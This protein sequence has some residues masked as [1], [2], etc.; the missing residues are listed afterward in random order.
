MRKLVLLLLFL[1]SCQIPSQLP[2]QKTAKG[3]V[4][5]EI[6]TGTSALDVS[7]NPN[8]ISD[9]L[10]C[11]QANVMVDMRNSG[12]YNIDDGSFTF[13]FE[14][15]YF[16]AV[17]SSKGDFSL[18]G[19]S[20]FNPQGD[21]MLKEFRIKNKGLPSQLE[22]Y[23]S[24]L[25]FLACY[26]YKTFGTVQVCVDPDIMNLNPNKPCRIEPVA[27]SGGQGAPVAVTRV[28]TLMV[29][30]EEQVRPAFAVFIQHLGSGSVVS[31]EGAKLACTAEKIK[32][33]EL[34][35]KVSVNVKVKDL[36]LDCP[37]ELVRLEADKE[38]RVICKFP[39]LIGMNSGTYST[40]LSV[41]IDYGYVSSALLPVSV[42]RL[43][44]QT[45][46]TR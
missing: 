41:E 46:C 35:S 40:V 13:I 18:D 7:F 38:S 8:S 22:S 43:A 14:D 44:G 23:V 15:Q 24:P 12:A 9:V 31:K 37:D 5:Q 4:V 27:L 32:I 45:A 28:E 26:T 3:P 6:M 25:I 33:G 42:T 11:Q 16:E 34:L 29:P 39:E 2:F 17:G 30:E 1:V 10:M 36:V 20:Y 21:F 19:K